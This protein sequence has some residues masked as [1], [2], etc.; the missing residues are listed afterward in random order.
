MKIKSSDKL[1]RLV[2]FLCLFILSHFLL[3]SQDRNKPAIAD[4]E[5]S[6]F[7]MVN[8]AR[9]QCG[10]PKL[11]WSSRLQS[12]SRQHSQDM[13]QQNAM[14]HLSSSGQS[15]T[16][17]LSEAKL[18]F[19]DHG[20]NVA[21][22]ESYVVDFIHRSFMDS[23]EHKANILDARYNVIGIGI[24]FQEN[25]GY[26]VTQDFLR[27]QMDPDTENQSEDLV[28]EPLVET[29]ATIAALLKQIKQDTHAAINAFRAEK[30]HPAFILQENAN[31]V[32]Q[33]F[34]IRKARKLS[35]PGLPEEIEQIQN[36]MIF[37]TAPDLESIRDKLSFFRN[38]YY[39]KGGLGI[40]YARNQ[41]Y[42]GG[43]YYFTIILLL[44]R[45]YEALP[46]KECINSLIENINVIRKRR[47]IEPINV[48]REL[49]KVAFYL[50]VGVSAGFE[51]ERLIPIQL[52][53]YQ[54]HTYKTKKTTEIPA[55][56]ISGLTKVNV[57]KVGIGMFLEENSD[58]AGDNF[59]VSI[60]F[61]E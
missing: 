22:S 16:D 13:A 55:E 50:S 53:R 38:R 52:R 41:N 19:M 21:F 39:D 2:I 43:A 9:T 6:L 10:Y 24:F 46:F 44:D 3:S 25:R 17:R 26:Y 59:W 29:D 28:R 60:V 47:K 4:M 23:P 7:E 30:S 42:P 49:A 40:A 37:Y 20:E 36:L 8:A 45:D 33:E 57:I 34:S 14:T 61:R 48:N 5:K 31:V 51:K 1:G 15:Y 54:I 32:A 56:I 18:I 11:Y 27:I 12:L 35:L 58:S